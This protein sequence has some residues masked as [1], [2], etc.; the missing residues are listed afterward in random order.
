[1][2]PAD[3]FHCFN[4]FT[5]GINREYLK[6]FLEI[7]PANSKFRK[8]T[9]ITSGCPKNQKRCWYKTGSPPPA[10][11]KKLVL[12][13]LSVNSMVIPPAKTGSDSN[14]NTAVTKIAQPNNG[15]LCNTCPGI[16][17]LMIVVMTIYII[18]NNKYMLYI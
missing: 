14:N 7:V 10:G 4:F 8:L 15:T 11:S 9:N 1:L 5:I 6:L 18:T 2:L 3:L 12:K 17:I 13:F 16:R